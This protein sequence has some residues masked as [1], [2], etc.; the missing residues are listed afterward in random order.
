MNKNFNI[1]VSKLLIAS[2]LVVGLGSFDF[3]F[4]SSEVF[5]NNAFQLQPLKGQIVVVPS[6]TAIPACASMEI[7][8]ETLQLW[9]NVT[10]ALSNDFYYNNNLVA[11]LGS[12][13]NGTV[14]NVKKAGRA[15]INGQILVKFTNIITPYGQMIPISGVIQTDAGNGLIKGGTK[16]DS[17]TDYAKDIAAGSAAGALTGVVFGPLSGGKAGKGAALGT[18]VGAG[19]GLAKSL[20]DRGTPA[21]IPVG[22]SVNV[23]LEQQATFMPIQGYQY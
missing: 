2:M 23:V 7:S 21:V 3:N 17:A 8:S 15:G 19:L 18:A 16:A 9:Q 22:T 20:W 13:I 6:G 4:V 1:N 12:S 10:L 5:A 14:I 11:P